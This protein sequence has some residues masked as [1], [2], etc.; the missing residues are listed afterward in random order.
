[1]TALYE[2][3][4]A[5]APNGGTS[6]IATLRVRYK[7]PLADATRELS[8]PVAGAVAVRPS[9]DFRVAA[10]AAALGMLLRGSAHTGTLGWDDLAAMAASPGLDAPDLARTV[11]AAHRLQPPSQPER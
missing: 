7:P 8:R 1:M 6:P 9:R 5:D 3:V 10:V 2:L 11:A 4:P